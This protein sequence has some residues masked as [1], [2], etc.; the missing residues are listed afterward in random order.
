MFSIKKRFEI[1]SALSEKSPPNISQR[2]KVM[3]IKK[4]A[5]V[6]SKIGL[7]FLIDSLDI[8]VLSV[9]RIPRRNKNTDKILEVISKLS[10]LGA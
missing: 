10:W 7:R 4:K 5:I 3:I 2:T 1:L 8:S 6:S 9:I